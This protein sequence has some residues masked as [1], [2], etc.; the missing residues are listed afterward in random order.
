MSERDNEGNLCA[1]PAAT[2]CDLRGEVGSQMRVN[3]L[4]YARGIALIVGVLTIGI[5]GKLCHAAVLPASTA[6]PVQ[7]THTLDAGKAKPGDAI[8]AKTMQIVRLPDGQILPK[9]ASVVGHVA[10]S[11]SF[12]FDPAPYAVQKPS[13]LS[14]HFDKIVTKDVE[15]PLKVSVRALASTIDVDDANTPQGIDESDHLGTMVQVGGD[16]FSPI[17]KEL[18][19]LNGD[20]VG[21][22]RKHG[23]FARLISNEYVDQYASCRCT[24]TTWPVPR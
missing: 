12:T 19:T 20:V 5:S 9:G 11:R 8:L 10:E 7:F 21:Y 15:I 3:R 6:I 24:R 4:P 16:Q 1:L 17:G 18:L 13:Y 22:I 2:R 23:V 14:I